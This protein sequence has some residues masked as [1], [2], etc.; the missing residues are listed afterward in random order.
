MNE[1]AKYLLCF[2]AGAI[3]QALI[4]QPKVRSAAIYI[5][6]FRWAKIGIAT[7]ND[8]RGKFVYHKDPRKTPKGYRRIYPR[9]HKGGAVEKQIDPYILARLR[10][11]KPKNKSEENK[12]IKQAWDEVSKKV[13][14]KQVLD[15]GDYMRDEYDYMRARIR[16]KK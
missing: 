6:T 2:I 14:P 1:G 5:F 7:R 15:H 16:R 8:A 12:V 10:K 13:Y 4:F 11:V 9:P 3:V